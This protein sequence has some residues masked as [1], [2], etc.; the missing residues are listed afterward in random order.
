[1]LP[2]DKAWKSMVL[3]TTY[4]RLSPYTSDIVQLIEDIREDDKDISDEN[5][6][7]FIRYETEIFKTGSFL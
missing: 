1:V 7:C 4:A 2:K 6:R 5:N 3:R